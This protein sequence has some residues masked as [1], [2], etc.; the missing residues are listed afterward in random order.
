M[1]HIGRC[2][3][4]SAG[5]RPGRLRRDNSDS[6]AG[7][8][9]SVSRRSRGRADQLREGRIVSKVGDSALPQP[10]FETGEDEVQVPVG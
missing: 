5:Q 4:V 9:A 2:V 6:G 3:R 7:P 8:A 1:R 10:V